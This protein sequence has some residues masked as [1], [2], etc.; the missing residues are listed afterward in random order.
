MSLD[1]VNINVGMGIDTLPYNI[2]P[3]ACGG[4]NSGWGTASMG[5]MDI[6]ATGLDSNFTD[7]DFEF[8]DDRK[9]Q[10]SGISTVSTVSTSVPPSLCIMP[11][12]R[13]LCTL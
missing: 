8:W 10:Q 11:R 12:N 7:A 6:D 9:P 1:D 13:N 3:T 5:R 4:G 2:D